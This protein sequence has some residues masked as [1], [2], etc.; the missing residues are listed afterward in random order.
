MDGA[1]RNAMTAAFSTCSMR[2][3]KLIQVLEILKMMVPH[4]NGSPERDGKEGEYTD[5]LITRY[6]E[7]SSRY[8]VEA[9]NAV[10]DMDSDERADRF[11]AFISSTPDCK[12]AKPGIEGM[13]SVE[14]LYSKL[15]WA[16][17]A[18][19]ALAALQASEKG[20]QQ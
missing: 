18:K 9:D 13:Q 17:R 1:V 11:V 20:G 3:A 15:N 12:G 19:P 10:V 7:R 2:G 16:L 14:R 4:M 8:L 6:P 5:C